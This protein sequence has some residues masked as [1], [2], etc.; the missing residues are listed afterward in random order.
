MILLLLLAYLSLSD[1][2]E[3]ACDSNTGVTR[4]TTSAK[5]LAGNG[6]LL[7]KSQI[8]RV[9]VTIVIVCK[10]VRGATFRIVVEGG[11]T[12]ASQTL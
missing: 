1:D 11:S 5:G 2:S 9:V 7:T 10:R 4:E 6:P 12:R 8:C 3:R